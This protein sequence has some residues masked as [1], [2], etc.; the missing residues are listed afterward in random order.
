ML[1]LPA[2][3]PTP[4]DLGAH[5]LLH[6]PEAVASRGAPAGATL[7][8]CAGTPHFRA[9]QL[10]P[11]GLGEGLCRLPSLPAWGLGPGRASS[12]ASL[13]R[14]ACLLSGQGGQ[15]PERRVT[16]CLN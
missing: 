13:T 10:E 3:D 1:M 7:S 9:A 2:G 5:C 15:D 6:R 14:T 11:L 8:L 16:F 12:T 4:L